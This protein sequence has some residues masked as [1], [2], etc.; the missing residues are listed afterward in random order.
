[1]NDDYSCCVCLQL[2][3]KKLRLRVREYSES[4]GVLGTHKRFVFS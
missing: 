3:D 4:G 1:M 2:C